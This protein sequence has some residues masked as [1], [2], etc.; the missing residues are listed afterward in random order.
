MKNQNSTPLLQGSGLK[1]QIDN[2]AFEYQIKLKGDNIYHIAML[3]F[4]VES[5]VIEP[6]M[7]PGHHDS[8]LV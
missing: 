3:K 6:R 1:E 2:T 7:S 5:N 4:N 8:E